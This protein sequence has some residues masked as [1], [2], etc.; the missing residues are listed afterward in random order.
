MKKILSAIL[1]LVLTGSLLSSQAE[2]GSESLINTDSH[3]KG[4]INNDSQT[5]ITDLTLLSLN[6][7]GD[8]SFSPEQY[9]RAD[10]NYDKQV[11]IADLARFKQFVSH[12]KDVPVLED[13]DK[14]T[15][16]EEYRSYLSNYISMRMNNLVYSN[17]REDFP[18]SDT[19]YCNFRQIN[20]GSIKNNR[21][22][23]SSSPC[24]NEHNRA[25][26]SD[27]LMKEYGIGYIVNLADTPEY[28]ERYLSYDSY[29]FP[30][31]LS[32]MENDNVALSYVTT[33]YTSES[34]KTTIGNTLRTLPSHKGPYAVHCLEGM[35]RTGFVCLLLEAL[36][37]ASYSE[38]RDDYMKTYENYYRISKSKDKELYDYIVIQRLDSMI[39][40]LLLYSSSAKN[41]NSSNLSECAFNYLTDCGMNEAEIN[42]LKNAL[43]K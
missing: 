36:C 32:L 2:Q 8:F 31:T 15:A 39:K 6:L 34:F 37:D 7:L 42:E 40:Y 30:Y 22:Y 17:A 19:I 24:D 14:I 29:S 3:P 38:I 35:H 13:P 26:Y 11:D 41:N 43:C 27:N 33:D 16:E 21:L 9:V 18:D 23:R 25:P 5:D 1:A 4:D 10:V 12:D 28:I 20:C